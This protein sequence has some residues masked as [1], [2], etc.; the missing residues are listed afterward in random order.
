MGYRPTQLQH[1]C[2]ANQANVTDV[3]Q[4]TIA[5]ALPGKP[6]GRHIS[7]HRTIRTRVELAHWI[8]GVLLQLQLHHSEPNHA[9]RSRML[10]R[11]HYSAKIRES[12]QRPQTPPPS[13]HLTGSQDSRGE[14]GHAPCRFCCW[15][16]QALDKVGPE[17]Y[18]GFFWLSLCGQKYGDVG[19]EVGRFSF[20]RVLGSRLPCGSKCYHW[21]RTNHWGTSKVLNK[22]N[23]MSSPLLLCSS[24]TRLRPSLGW[25]KTDVLEP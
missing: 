5:T 3:C 10:S 23:C 19:A 9:G 20:G 12:R 21:C 24:I 1:C 2:Q 22:L 17:H 13:S 8:P 18:Q 7:S 6:T 25:D 4:P 15:I 11:C 16:Q 14:G